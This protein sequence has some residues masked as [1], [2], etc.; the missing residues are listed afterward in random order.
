[1]MNERG[2]LPILG[3]FDEGLLMMSAPRLSD[4]LVL[5]PTPS[6]PHDFGNR[7]RIYQVCAGLKQR[8]ARISFIHYPLEMDWRTHCPAEPLAQMRKEWHDVH[9]VAPSVP[10]HAS[11]RG[12]DHALDEWWDPALESFLRWYL[13]A[14][15]FDALLVN[16]LYLSRALTL[17]PRNCVGILDTHDKFAGRRQLL[18]SIGIAPEF[19]HT[20]EAD[21][22]SGIE[23]A[24]LVLAIKEQEQ[25]YFE[26]LASRNV[27]TLPFAEPLRGNATPAPDPDGHLRVGILGARNNINL[28]NVRRFLELAVPY[29][30]R[31]FAPMRFVLA[32]TMCRDLGPVFGNDT[33][34]EL[35]GPIDNVEEFYDNVDV[36]VVPMDASSGQKIK[37]GESLAFGLP[38]IAHAHAFEGYPPC[39]KLHTC[40]SFEDMADAC[41]DLAF[42]RERLADLAVASRSSAA[43]Q[44]RASGAALDSV[45]DYVDTSR[46]RDVFVVDAE[47]L[48]HDTFLQAHLLSMAH[49]ASVLGRVVF[50]LQGDVGRGLNEFIVEARAWSQIYATGTCDALAQAECVGV[51]ADIDALLRKSNISRIWL[52][53]TP[54][55]GEVMRQQ[56]PIVA[57]RHLTRC[58]AI[59]QWPASVVNTNGLDF[60]I[61]AFR[62]DGAAMPAF[63]VREAFASSAT[64]SMRLR[65][66]ESRQ[67]SN[68]TATIWVIASP[69]NGALASAFVH[70]LLQSPRSE[71]VLSIGSGDGG[72][73]AAKTTRRFRHIATDD[74]AL[75]RERSKPTLV[76]DLTSRDDLGH[77]YAA[78]FEGTTVPLWRPGLAVRALQ[79]GGATTACPLP[80]LVDAYLRVIRSS[81][82]VSVPG[83]VETRPDLTGLYNRLATSY[84]F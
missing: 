41:V 72:G 7:K 53:D 81:A 70:M 47:R 16:Y 35:L 80:V 45:I 2:L 8:G 54:S 29:A 28:Y 20:T 68:G 46:Q 6:H 75:G 79:A 23:R 25:A 71:N 76:V 24:D 32:G 55:L 3:W 61:G 22:R 58:S 38:L 21:E 17:R 37:V 14:R 42:H 5:S 30:K 43:A 9:V 36:V 52:Y 66:F 84:V 82:P 62:D 15:H 11:A 1:M 4:I 83:I 59:G 65:S 49:L 51:I 73:P 40:K 13:N 48:S 56:I 50:V 69:A 77:V 67:L 27:L 26:R 39:H 12:A 78:M 63:D 64:D 31:H 44:L 33:M 57:V 10:I 19:F 60:V 34:I 74:F 18:S